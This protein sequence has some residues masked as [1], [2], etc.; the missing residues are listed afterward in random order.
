MDS[1]LC[2]VLI[3]WVADVALHTLAAGRCSLHILTADVA[4]YRWS[5][6]T[7]S[8]ALKCVGPSTRDMRSF[9]T[10]GRTWQWSFKTGLTVDINAQSMAFISC[11]IV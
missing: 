3:D 7:G 1:K 8:I 11:N 10:G 5:L 9:K 2:R 4:S 6:V